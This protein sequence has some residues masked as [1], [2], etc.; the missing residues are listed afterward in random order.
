MATV[1]R[2]HTRA[3]GAD[4]SC[5]SRRS[6]ACWRSIT[7]AS[8]TGCW[9][10]SPKR[11]CPRVRTRRSRARGTA[12]GAAA[13]RFAPPRPASARPRSSS[14]RSGSATHRHDEVVVLHRPRIGRGRTSNPRHDHRGWVAAQTC[15]EVEQVGH[16]RLVRHRVVRSTDLLHQISPCPGPRSNHMPGRR[17]RS[18]RHPVVS[19]AC[20]RLPAINVT[21]IKGTALQQTGRV[22]LEDAGIAGNRRFHLIDERGRLFSGSSFG[23]LVQ[24]VASHD[25]IA[26]VLTC[27]FPDGSTVEAPDDS[28]GPPARDRLLRTAGGRTRAERPVRRGL[29]VVRRA[30]GVRDPHRSRRRRARRAA[31]DRDLALPPWPTWGDAGASRAISTRS[32]SGSI[33]SSTAA[34]RSRRTVGTACCVQVGTAVIRIAWTDPPLRRH[35]AGPAHGPAR[36]EHAEADR[37][38]PAAHGRPNGDP[39]RGLRDGREARRGRAWRRGC[40]ARHLTTW[41]MGRTPPFGV[42]GA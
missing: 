15:L 3:W 30:T 9:L 12:A 32:G 20:R 6:T 16:D 19:P 40:V 18:I 38:V 1:P 28:L 5:V 39:V 27:R 21:P 4:Q 17:L 22:A 29:L 42:S 10:L 14:E 34:R 31:A 13:P 23:P 7:F 33:W 11:R 41:G 37:R 25:P 2:G 36:L 24:V 26:G 8:A 35:H